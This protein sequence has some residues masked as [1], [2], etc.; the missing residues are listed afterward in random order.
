MTKDEY[1][2]AKASQYIGQEETSAQENG[3]DY[4]K[5]EIDCLRQGFRAGFEAG[6]EYYR[7]CVLDINESD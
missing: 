2:N 1:L 3:Y 7:K 5:E 4:G 6:C